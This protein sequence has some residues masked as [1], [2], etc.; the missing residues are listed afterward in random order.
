VLAFTCHPEEQSAARQAEHGQW[1][2]W[3]VAGEPGGSLLGPWD[4]SGA[5]PF[6]AEPALFAAPLVP[7]RDGSWALLGFRNQEPQ[8]ID[9]FEI[10]DPVG[11]LVQDGGLQAHAG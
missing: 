1:C 2:T 10:I 3:S 11:V 6:R 5:V 8:G 7:R 9:S 4:L